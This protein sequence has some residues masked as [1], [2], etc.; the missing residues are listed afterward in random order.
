MTSLDGFLNTDINYP[1]IE[2]K[3]ELIL[4][5]EYLS[6]METGIQAICSNYIKEEEQKHEDEEYCE[7]R[8]IYIK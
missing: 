5:R 1:G 3:V 6:Q 8:Y 2:I 7:Y 4:M